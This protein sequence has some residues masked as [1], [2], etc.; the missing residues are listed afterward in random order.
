L[1]GRGLGVVLKF[2]AV[3]R[4]PEWKGNCWTAITCVYLSGGILQLIVVSRL[5]WSS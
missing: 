1:L 5:D 3:Q 4:M 2:L